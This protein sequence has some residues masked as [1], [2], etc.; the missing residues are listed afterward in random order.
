MICARISSK[1]IGGSG[2]HRSTSTA[3]ATT[4]PATARGS[5]KGGKS[6]AREASWCEPHRRIAQQQQQ[7]AEAALATKATHGR[8]HGSDTLRSPTSSTPAASTSWTSEPDD[9]VEAV[10]VRVQ[11]ATTTIMRA[12]SRR[13]V[14]RVVQPYSLRRAS[15]R[16]TGDVGRRIVDVELPQLYNLAWYSVP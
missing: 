8:P 14:V 5:S 6:S 12:T 10:Q 2:S 13:S 1:R 4:A 9:S 16:R 7:P 3:T 11:A 15:H